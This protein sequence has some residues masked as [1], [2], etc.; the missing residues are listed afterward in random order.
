MQVGTFVKTLSPHVV[1]IL[2][3]TG[4][5]FAAI[6]A[7]HAPFDR[8]ALDLMMLAGRAARLPIHVR[9]PDT[10]PATILSVLDVGAAGLV[11]PHVVIVGS[12]QS[13]LRQAAQGVAAKT[14]DRRP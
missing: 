11:V 4:L 6:D 2:G 5:D 13:L 9:I 7:E 8:A 14:P 3:P 10:A 1:E 12:D